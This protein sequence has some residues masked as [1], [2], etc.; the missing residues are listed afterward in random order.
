MYDNIKN[1]FSTNISIKTNNQKESFSGFMD[2]QNNKISSKNKY[3]EY[4]INSKVFHPK[5]GVGTIVAMENVD[6]SVYVS[7][8]FDKIGVKKLSLEFAPI[9][10]MK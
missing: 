1:S 5:F 10:L 2:F 9:K 6:G 7:C 8:Q 4:K 3:S